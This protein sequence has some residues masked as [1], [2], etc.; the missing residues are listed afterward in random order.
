M[1][2]NNRLIA[3]LLGLAISAM[4]FTACGPKG[5]QQTTAVG[6]VEESSVAETTAKASAEEKG[7]TRVVTDMKGVQVEIPKEV[8]T[9]VE[10]WYAHNEVDLMLNRAEGMAITCVSP[11]KF[12][13]MYAI[14]PNFYKAT[15]ATFATD[16][17]LEEIIAAK[18]DVVFGSNEDYRAMFNNAGIPYIN[19]MFTTY[20]ELKKSVRLTGEVLG[21]DAVQKAEDYVKYMEDR[22]AWVGEKTAS[23]PE[24]QRATVAH[25]SSVYEL[26]FDGANTIIDEWI[27]LSGGVNAA[28]KE[29]EGN[30]KN[31]SLEQVMAWNPD[32]LITG[33]QQ[34][35]VEKILSDPAWADLNAVKNKKVYTN[36]KGAFAWDRYG[37]DTAL[38]PQWCAQ[39]LYPDLFKDFSI[40]DEVKKFYSTFLS[41]DLSDEEA[42]MILNNETPNLENYP[43]S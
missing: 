3:G 9:Y 42:Q 29:V 27:K 14:C 7:D 10:S 41:Y 22:V 19:C 38:Q 1:K 16:M 18:P 37:V 20:D 17:N 21:G 5:T 39:I 13:W 31:I 25:G 24:D 28:G 11:E 4:L 8:H 30:L 6:S 26:N 33:G 35:E 32:V 15:S 40:K 2:K 23:I 43:K 36:P 34:S 12:P